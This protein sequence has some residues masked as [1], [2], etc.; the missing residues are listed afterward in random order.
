MRLGSYIEVLSGGLECR[1]A[2]WLCNPFCNYLSYAYFGRG[3]DITTNARPRQT[4]AK[5]G[6]KIVTIHFYLYSKIKKD[7]LTED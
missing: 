7:L 4:C 1:M 3:H 6:E 5:S 2:A